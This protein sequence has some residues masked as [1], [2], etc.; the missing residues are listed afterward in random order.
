MGQSSRGATITPMPD[1]DGCEVYGCQT[2]ELIALIEPDARD[3]RR[4]LCPEHRVEYL[5]EVYD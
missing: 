5:Q 3:E 4:V 1:R 2:T